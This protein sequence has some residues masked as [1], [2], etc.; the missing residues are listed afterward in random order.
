MYVKI[1]VGNFDITEVWDGVF[2]KKLSKYP[3]ISEWEMRNIIEFVEYEK[4]NGRKCDIECDNKDLL[5]K[6][7]KGIDNKELYIKTNRPV[8]I[9][10][11]TACPYRK[12]CVTDFV[13]HTTSLENAKKIFNSGKLLSAVKARNLSAQELAKENRNAANDPLDYFDYI[14]FAWGNCQAGDRLVMERKLKRFPNEEDLS[15]NFTPGIRFYFKYDVLKNHPNVVYDGVLP[16]K[17][18]DELLL[19]EWVYKIVIPKQYQREFQNII[20]SNLSDK[21]IYVDN[22]CKDIW[23]WSEKVYKII[24]SCN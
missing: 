12:G 11:C 19:S 2:Y 24:E 4:I 3:E 23:D 21:I 17:I 5:N 20:P 13:C 6:I 8:L 10:E 1:K 18:K 22:D 15:I 7:I 9:K 16:M 14:M